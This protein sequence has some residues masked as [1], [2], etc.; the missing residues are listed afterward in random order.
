MIQEN[1]HR[2]LFVFVTVHCFGENGGKGISHRLILT[3]LKAQKN[4]VKTK[5]IWDTFNY[6]NQKK[7]INTIST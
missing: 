3:N 4:I 7:T 5:V 6:L 1:Y 2:V